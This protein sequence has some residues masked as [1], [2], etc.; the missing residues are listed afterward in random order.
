MQSMMDSRQLRNHNR[1]THTVDREVSFDNRGLVQTNRHKL[2]FNLNLTNKL[3]A[4]NGGRSYVP[5]MYRSMDG[6]AVLKKDFAYKPVMQSNLLDY[7]MT[8]PDIMNAT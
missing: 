2:E 7:E 1:Y 3:I 5:D 6:S 4:K 8:K